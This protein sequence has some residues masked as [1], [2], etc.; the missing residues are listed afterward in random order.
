M[1]QRC[2]IYYRSGGETKAPEQNT[3]KGGAPIINGKLHT[4]KK[5]RGEEEE[6]EEEEQDEEEEEDGEDK[7]SL[8]MAGISPGPQRNGA[9][10]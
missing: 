7:T 6:N 9:R 10:C 8:K 1:F 4:K 3:L 5:E 2:L